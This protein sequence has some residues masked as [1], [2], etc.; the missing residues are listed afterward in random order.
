MHGIKKLR[1]LF[2]LLFDNDPITGLI[3]LG[4][5][6]FQSPQMFPPTHIPLANASA[7]VQP[8]HH[9]IDVVD[10]RF[11]YIRLIRIYH[12]IGA[13]GSAVVLTSYLMRWCVLIGNDI[14]NDGHF[15]T[16]TKA[17][18]AIASPG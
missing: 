18:L 3:Q 14:L 15:R 5:R 17:L 6:W 16:W 7:T 2:P 11:E 9:L 10:D 13:V 12:T 1:I 8:T 4:S